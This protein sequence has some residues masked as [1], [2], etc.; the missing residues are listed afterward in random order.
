LV[1]FQSREAGRPRLRAG[2]VDAIKFRPGERCVLLVEGLS[3]TL[4]SGVRVL[5]NPS[6][7]T[8]SKEVWPGGEASNPK[9]KGIVREGWWAVVGE[10]FG[11]AWEAVGMADLARTPE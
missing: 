9:P 10:C 4:E 11:W 5:G 1:G 8:A 7:V 2:E 3:W 6:D